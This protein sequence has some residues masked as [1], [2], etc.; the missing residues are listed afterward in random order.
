MCLINKINISVITYVFFSVLQRIFCVLLTTQQ[1]CDWF[2]YLVCIFHKVSSLYVLSM[3]IT[4][5]IST[6]AY[7][8]RSIKLMK[9]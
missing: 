8:N 1:S 6:W 4:Y 2:Y 5:Y 7:K 3:N 9:P